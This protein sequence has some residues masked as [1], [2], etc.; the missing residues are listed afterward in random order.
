M[1]VE[2]RSRTI[3]DPYGNKFIETVSEN[4]F[5][6]SLKNNNELIFLNEHNLN[7]QLASTQEETLGVRTLSDES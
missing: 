3:T 2:E 6:D 1:P 7:S 5:R 4:A